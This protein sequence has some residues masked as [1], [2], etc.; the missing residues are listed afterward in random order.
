MLVR[1]KDAEDLEAWV[2]W[3]RGLAGDV[4]VTLLARELSPECSSR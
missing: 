4:L 1:L 3:R 2:P